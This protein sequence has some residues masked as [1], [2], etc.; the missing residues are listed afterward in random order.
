[1]EGAPLVGG[2]ARQGPTLAAYWLLPPLP[3]RGHAGAAI[4]R[5]SVRDRVPVALFQAVASI[6]RARRFFAAPALGQP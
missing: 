3:D 2:A 5:P 6:S 1:M 4:Q